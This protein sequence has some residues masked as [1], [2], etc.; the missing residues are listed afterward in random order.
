MD[1]E[2]GIREFARSSF[3]TTFTIEYNPKKHQKHTKLNPTRAPVGCTWKWELPNRLLWGVVMDQSLTDPKSAPKIL[4]AFIEIEE[5]EI[6]EPL[7][8]EMQVYSTKDP[9]IGRETD[10]E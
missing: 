9:E 2:L 6:T 7:V 3:G 5:D 4:E 1:P 10:Q 8:L